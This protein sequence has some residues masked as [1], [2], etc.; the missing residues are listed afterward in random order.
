MLGYIRDPK[1]CRSQYIAAYFGDTKV[2]ACGICDHCLANK[3][4]ELTTE[5]FKQI[6]ERIIAIIGK[7]AVTVPELL[8]Q[9]NGTHKEKVWQ[10]LNFLQAEQKI[11]ANEKG[12]LKAIN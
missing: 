8:Q 3:Q 11:A 6:H 12:I 10:V 9:M 1:Q 4:G 5:E 7:G 2:R